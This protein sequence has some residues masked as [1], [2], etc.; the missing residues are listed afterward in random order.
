MTLLKMSKKHFAPFNL[1]I[2]T[3][4]LRRDDIQPAVSHGTLFSPDPA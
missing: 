3:D 1:Y 2:G 4:P